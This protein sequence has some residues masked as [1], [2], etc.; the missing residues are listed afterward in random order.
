MPFGDFGHANGSLAHD[1]LTI[2]PSLPGNHQVGLGYLLFQLRLGQ[3]NLDTRFQLGL[4][5]GEKSKS[6]PASRPGAGSFRFGLREFP[7][8]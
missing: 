4:S 8:G 2:Q 5:I 3:N 7:A 1:G 6:Q